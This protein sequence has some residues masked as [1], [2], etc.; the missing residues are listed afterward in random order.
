MTK[1][2]KRSLRLTDIKLIL[3][4][5]SPFFWLFLITAIIMLVFVVKTKNAK[6]KLIVANLIAIPLALLI[7]ETYCC[8]LKIEHPKEVVKYD[9]KFWEPSAHLGWKPIKNNKVRSWATLKEK[10]IFDAYYTIDEDGL[11]DTP[12][13]NKKSNQCVSFFGC[14]FTFGWGLNDNETLPY[15]FGKQTNQKYKISNFAFNGYAANQMLSQIEN[16]LME[17]N[18]TRCSQNIAIFSLMDDQIKR[19]LG[20]TIWTDRDPMFRIKNKKLTYCGSFNNKWTA[21]PEPLFK[22]KRKFELYT[23][24]RKHFIE[25]INKNTKEN[26]EELEIAILNKSRQLLKEKYNTDRFI[27]LIWNGFEDDDKIIEK[28]KANH[29]EYYLMSDILPDY[30]YYSTKYHIEHDWHPNKIAN[31]IIAKFLAQKVSAK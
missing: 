6:K 30:G 31:E 16:G 19:V 4:V 18:T 5:L 13:S 29:F 22:I 1:P 10:K 26:P 17:I 3:S 15:F 27:I 23:Y 20:E 8:L 24:L 9:H 12:S 25:K 14:S 21:M 7:G 2:G 28:L 11:R